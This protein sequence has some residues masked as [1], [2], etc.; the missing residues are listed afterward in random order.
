M[1]NED[2][3]NINTVAL[4]DRRSNDWQRRL[5]LVAEMSIRRWCY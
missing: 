3:E 4:L 2:D 5:M 1:Q